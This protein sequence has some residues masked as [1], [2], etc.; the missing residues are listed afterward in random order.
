MYILLNCVDSPRI[1]KKSAIKDVKKVKKVG[2]EG[3][4]IQ[5]SFYGTNLCPLTV[6]G[7]VAE[8]YRYLNT[9]K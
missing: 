2:L 8:F 4:Y 3:E 7:T 6:K 1:R 9:V 5:V